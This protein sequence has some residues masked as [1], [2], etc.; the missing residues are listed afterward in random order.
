MVPPPS[1]TELPEPPASLPNTAP[2]T[3]KLSELLATI[4]ENY[5]KYHLL[6]EQLQGLQ[7]WIL[8]QKE[9]HKSR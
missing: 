4:N 1:L 3:V 8:K 7:N 9:L 6:S 2:S 5:T